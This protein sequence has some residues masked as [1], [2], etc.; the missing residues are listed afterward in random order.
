MLKTKVLILLRI[1]VFLLALLICVGGCVSSSIAPPAQE[2]TKIG[3]VTI[4]AVEPPPLAIAVGTSLGLAGF[5][6]NVP[7]LAPTAPDS[8]SD[9]MMTLVRESLES[10]GSWNPSRVMAQEAMRQLL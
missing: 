1:K 5:A 8:K 4:V 9:P 7:V 6:G 2:L 3:Q 10:G